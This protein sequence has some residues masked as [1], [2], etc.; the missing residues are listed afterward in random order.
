MIDQEH[1][2]I[3]Q[4]AA[5]PAQKSS[6]VASAPF[7]RDPDAQPVPVTDGSGPVVQ[8]HRIIDALFFGMAWD[9]GARLSL[10]DAGDLEL[11]AS[12]R[13]M[14]QNWIEGEMS[15]FDIPT[16]ATVAR[17]PN[18]SIRIQVWIWPD[19]QKVFDRVYAYNLGKVI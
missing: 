8:L 10:A 6:G 17:H 14:A 19:Q 11:R 5:A 7:S 18:N 3:A 15:R 16:L 4:M 9:E 1:K 13:V 12:S 2:T